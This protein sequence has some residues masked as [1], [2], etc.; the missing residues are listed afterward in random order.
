MEA[1]DRLT[2]RYIE[3]GGKL[4]V[5]HPELLLGEKRHVVYFHDESCFHACDFEKGMFLHTSQQKM[6]RKGSK[7]ALIL[8]S[9]APREGLQLV[10][11]TEI[12]IEM[13]GSPLSGRHTTQLLAQI[14]DTLDIFEQKHSGCVAV[15]IFGQSSAH[16]SHGSGALNAFNM[17]LSP[18][19]KQL[20]QNDTVCDGLVRLVVCLLSSLVL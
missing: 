6:P 17:N 7:G 19:G 8:T 15:L 3:V 14:K 12:L 1:I 5:S 9:L 16:N 2:T 11:T 18:G 10:T 20:P 4:E 13:Q